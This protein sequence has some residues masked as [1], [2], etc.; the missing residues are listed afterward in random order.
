MAKMYD[1][2]FLKNENNKKY[3]QIIIV[4]KSNRK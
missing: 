3:E 2:M 4:K 1:K